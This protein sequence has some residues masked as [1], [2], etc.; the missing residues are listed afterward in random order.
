MKVISGKL[1]GRLIDGFNIEGTRPTMDRVKES[2]FSSIQ[3]N[4][5]GSIVLDL[6]AGTGTYGIEAISNYAK[7]VYFN[8]YN[9]ECIKVIKK[10]LE[11][12][13]VLD[14][15]IFYNLDYLKCLNTLKK[16]KIK[17]DLVFLDPPYKLH[18]IDDIL[19]ILIKS[20][21]LNKEALI[22]CEFEDF[23][24]DKEYNNLIKIKDKKYGSK[25]VYIYKYI[26][27]N[28]EKK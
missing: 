14:Q 24:L 26:G 2:I 12:F 8:D 25:K 1:K 27:D 13:K 15:G 11:R 19:N 10:N 20:D 5:A 18:V 21:L 7:I 16:D 9:K 17:F 28:Y 22:I 3:D 23:L 6:F 4:I